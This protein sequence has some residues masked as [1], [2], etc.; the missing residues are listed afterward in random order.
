[1]KDAASNL[2]VRGGNRLDVFVTQ[3]D[4]TNL[5]VSITDLGTGSYTVSYTPVQAGAHS[6]F[7][8]ITCRSNFV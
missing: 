7:E 2:L 4:A 1:M 3:P 8:C 6:G 5:P